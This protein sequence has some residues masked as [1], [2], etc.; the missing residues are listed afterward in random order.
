MLNGS[1]SPSGNSRSTSHTRP[2][3]L[4]SVCFRDFLISFIYTGWRGKQEQ[5]RDMW[6]V[7]NSLQIDADFRETSLQPPSESVTQSWERQTW[8]QITTQEAAPNKAGLGNSKLKFQKETLFVLHCHGI[9]SSQITYY[10]TT[11][12]M[13]G[14]SL[15]SPKAV[16]S[17]S[18]ME[19]NGIKLFF[20]QGI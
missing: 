7:F 2:A 6:E 3:C 11:V 13:L 12:K 15:S 14:G 16:R 8:S 1:N 17:R 5:K 19:S 10:L 9:K 18:Q 4:S 20:F